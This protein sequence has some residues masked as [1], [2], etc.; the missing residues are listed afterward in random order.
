[1]GL[2]RVNW[3]DRSI[4]PQTDSRVCYVDL[5][6]WINRPRKRAFFFFFFFAMKR[7]RAL[8]MCKLQSWLFGS[9]N[10]LDHATN[11]LSFRIKAAVRLVEFKSCSFYKKLYVLIILHVIV[12]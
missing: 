6:W 11:F 5:V 2:V 10:P 4:G 12:N 3:N 1:M 7:K 9:V 8:P